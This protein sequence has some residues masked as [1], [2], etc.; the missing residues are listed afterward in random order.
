MI[1]STNKVGTICRCRPIYQD[2]HLQQDYANITFLK[3]IDP[4]SNWSKLKS[5]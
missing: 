2:I 3:L 1:L 4:K 5:F